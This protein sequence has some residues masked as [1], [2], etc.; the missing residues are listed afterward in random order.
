[1][2][3]SGTEP[4]PVELKVQSPHRWTTRD[5]QKLLSLKLG[6]G[7]R[8]PGFALKHSAE[9]KLCP[10]KNT[11]PEAMDTRFQMRLFDG[12]KLRTDTFVKWGKGSDWKRA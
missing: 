4:G 11:L 6:S 8:L 2:P 1:M 10:E 7:I 12:E 3:R 5:S 9:G